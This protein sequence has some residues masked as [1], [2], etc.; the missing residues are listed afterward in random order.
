MKKNT[1]Q[2][3]WLTFYFDDGGRDSREEAKNTGKGNRHLMEKK[4]VLELLE[5]I[6]FL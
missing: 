1:S 6:A 4:L 5:G 3:I 2:I